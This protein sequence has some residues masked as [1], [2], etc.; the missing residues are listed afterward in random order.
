MSDGNGDPQQQQECEQDQEES[1]LL[2]A[3]LRDILQQ[4]R[5]VMNFE[6]YTPSAAHVARMQQLKKAAPHLYDNPTLTP[7]STWFDHPRW[8]EN[9]QMP[10]FHVHYREEMQTVLRWLGKA[11]ERVVAADADD[12]DQGATTA[13]AMIRKAQAH[14]LSSMRGLDGHV[15]IEEY[16]CFPL[17]EQVYPEVN[18]RFLY[19]DHKALHAAEKE[20]KAVLERLTMIEDKGVTRVMIL[21]AIQIMLDFDAQ[22]VAHLGEEEEIVVPM[23]L[24]EKEIWF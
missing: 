20:V 21:D 13:R 10:P 7:R 18:I 12:D 16:A 24:T 5:T 2:F 11:Y 1:V 6:H 8:Y 15:S 23:S 19:Q 22:L 9:S 3:K 4:N 17:Y 14:F